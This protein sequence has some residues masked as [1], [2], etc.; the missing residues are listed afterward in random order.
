[1]KLFFVMNPFFLSIIS[2]NDRI[3]NMRILYLIS[4]AFM[5]SA[6][7]GTD[8]KVPWLLVIMVVKL[9]AAIFL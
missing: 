4:C 8:W 9:L 1:M 2:V 6:N 7:A 5:G 3:N